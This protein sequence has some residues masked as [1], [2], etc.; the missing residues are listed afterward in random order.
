M[1]ARR[2]LE[3][4]GGEESFANVRRHRAK[5]RGGLA[6]VLVTAGPNDAAPS[7]QIET[8]RPVIKSHERRDKPP[9]E[10]TRHPRTRCSTERVRR[11][12]KREHYRHGQE[13]ASVRV[14]IRI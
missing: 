8:R 14:T 11:A 1:T 7:A 3:A 2:T 4:V 13:Q 9:S 5:L 6:D 10:G 12:C